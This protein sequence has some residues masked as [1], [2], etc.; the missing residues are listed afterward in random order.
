MHAIS[1]EELLRVWEFGQFRPPPHRALMLLAASSPSVSREELE[2]MSIGERDAH[3]LELRESL[4]GPQFAGL[5]ECPSCKSNIEIDFDS[6]EIK[7]FDSKQDGPFRF[8]FGDYEFKCRLPNSADLFQLKESSDLDEMKMSILDK[9]LLEKKFKG[10]EVSLSQLPNEAIDACNA[11]LSLRDPQADVSL[12]LVCPD[13]SH[14]WE[15]IFDIVSFAW[16]EISVW[17][18][19]LLRQIH[20]IAAGYGW[21]EQEILA[22]SPL[23]RQAYL[24]MLRA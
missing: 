1:A 5:S 24:E 22:L 6:S 10:A 21:H 9:C 3:L 23:R 15:V 19:R 17:A 14:R 20:I 4:F 13:C 16:Q 11:E 12:S 7:S 2:Q 8:A 18:G